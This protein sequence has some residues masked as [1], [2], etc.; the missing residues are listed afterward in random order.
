MRTP[1]IALKAFKYALWG[2]FF[3]SDYREET[4]QN[5]N[6]KIPHQKP[7]QKHKTKCTKQKWV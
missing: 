5:N 1:E 3:A 7:T 2:F 4:L 6:Q